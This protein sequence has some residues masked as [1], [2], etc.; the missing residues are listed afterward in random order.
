ML[1]ILYVRLTRVYNW[2]R[3]MGN[4]FLK[5]QEISKERKGYRL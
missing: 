2:N 4:H 1:M 3:I 5:S